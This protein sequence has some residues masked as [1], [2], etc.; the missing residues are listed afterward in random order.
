MTQIY[1]QIGGDVVT[2]G[3]NLPRQVVFDGTGD[4]REIDALLSQAQMRMQL[5]RS[6]AKL[7]QSEHFTSH[8]QPSQSPTANVDHTTFAIY[9]KMTATLFAMS[10]CPRAQAFRQF[11]CQSESVSGNDIKMI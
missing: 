4:L 8:P 6:T 1:G 3:Y 9:I 10:S 11:H 7:E 2:C 5:L